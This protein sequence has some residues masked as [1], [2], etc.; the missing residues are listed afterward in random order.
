MVCPKCNSQNINTQ[1]VT[2]V[3]MKNKHHGLIY[4]LCLGWLLDL[5]LWLF[6]TVPK[7]IFVIFGHKK[8]KIVTKNYTMAV[9]QNCGNSWK[10]KG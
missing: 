4:W 7:L 8:Q 6:L 5:F 9:C 1:I 3:T 2:D 10:I